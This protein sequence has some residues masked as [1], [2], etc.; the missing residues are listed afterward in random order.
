MGIKKSI[1][2]GE[3]IGD[4]VYLHD[5]DHADRRHSKF[6]CHCGNEFITRTSRIVS[7]SSKGCG[8]LIGKNLIEIVKHNHPGQTHGFCKNHRPEYAVWNSMLSRCTNP[9][10]RAYG[11]YGGR[12]VKVCHRWYRF[13]GFISDMGARPSNI[14]S[15]ERINNDGNYEPEN[16][17]W[18]LP[19]EQRANRP[20]NRIIEFKG[21]AKAAFLW[22][23]EY[24]ISGRVIL[25]R[26]AR[27]WD[28]ERAITTSNMRSK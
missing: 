22:G 28:S 7:G 19:D 21:E 9:N 16:C 3:K 13:E 15:I 5:V 12:G 4:C 8:C 23:K 24:G 2:P 1:S 26:I 25:K 27:G 6:I 11:R 10:N 14:H 17:K 20:D 18:A